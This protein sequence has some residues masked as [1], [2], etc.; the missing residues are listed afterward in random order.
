MNLYLVDAANKSAQLPGHKLF[1]DQVVSQI[2][3]NNAIAANNTAQTAQRQ[4]ELP[5]STAIGELYRGPKGVFIK[6]A[7]RAG[8]AAAGL[9]IGASS[10]TSAVSNMFKQPQG[11]LRPT[12]N[13]R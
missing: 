12:P 10:A 6:G 5:E 2:R 7:E 13:R 3:Q 9:G 11:D 4:A 8:Q 1:V